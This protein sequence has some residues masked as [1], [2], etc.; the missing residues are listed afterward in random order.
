MKKKRN[1][2]PIGILL[3]IAIGVILLVDLVRWSIK[4][5]IIDENAYF[6]KY[7]D[8]EKNINLILQDTKD[9]EMHFTIFV[10]VNAKPVYD[11]VEIPLSPYFV[12]GHRD[13][14]KTEPKVELFTNTS[15]QI[16]AY[17]IP[18]MPDLETKDIKINLY[19]QRYHLKDA[20]LNLGEMLCENNEC[21]SKSFDIDVGGRWKVILEIAYPQGSDGIKKIYLEKEFFAALH[22]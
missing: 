7:S 14:N 18:K 9:F 17:I 15:N 10:S 8:V 19:L 2:W 11:A 3:I 12:K 5:P 4:K 13:K 20:S 21:V 6:E 16:Y 22:P 1:F